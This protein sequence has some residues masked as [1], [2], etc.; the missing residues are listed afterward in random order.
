MRQRVALLTGITGQ[1]GSYCAELL[2]AK[3]YK[4]F[5]LIRRSS[6]PRLER[7]THILD[8][9]ELLYGDITDQASLERALTD[10]RPDEVYNWCAQSFV[11][12]SFITPLATA[13]STGLGAL[14]LLEA[15]RATGQ[16]PRLFHASSSEMFGNAIL[17]PQDEE[18]PFR[19]VSP[20]GVAK[21]FAHL[22]MNVY[23]TSYKMYTCCGISFNHESERRGEEFVTRKIT[24]AVA[25]I[26]AGKQDVLSLGNL[27]ARRDWCHAEDVVEAA[28][29][30]LQQDTPRDYVLASGEAHTVQEFVE[31]A[32]N[33]AS[34]DYHQY[35]KFSPTYLRPTDVQSLCGNAARAYRYL[36]WRP[37][38]TFLQLVQRMVEHD[39]APAA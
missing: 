26:K 23:R 11:A 35:V 13:D 16:H 19:P 36:G 27:A 5:G 3:G 39:L 32:F 9:L 37:K 25:A 29:R 6:S 18:T 38:V 33:H 8:Q 31:A 2:L 20:Y 22:C 28:W 30:M 17:T 24:K 21:T 1:D 15:I 12:S 4:V 7:I 34:L 14:K 10:A